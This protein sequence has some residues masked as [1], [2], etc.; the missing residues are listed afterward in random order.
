M[1]KC[2]LEVSISAPR[3]LAGAVRTRVDD[4]SEAI[5]RLTPK[6]QCP[7]TPESALVFMIEKELGLVI[8]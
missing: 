5:S 2:P 7:S 4:G 1:Y 3:P 6:N 8:G